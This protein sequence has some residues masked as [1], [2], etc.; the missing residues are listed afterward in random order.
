MTHK[1]L[2]ASASY[3][4]GVPHAHVPIFPEIKEMSAK[5]ACIFWCKGTAAL[6]ITFGGAI[7][8]FYLLLAIL[9]NVLALLVGIFLVPCLVIVLFDVTTKRFK[10]LPPL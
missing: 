4:Y 5:E 9:P 2:K 1:K 3:E 7:S 8:S 6:L 10:L